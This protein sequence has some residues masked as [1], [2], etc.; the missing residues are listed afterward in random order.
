MKG[1]IV[2]EEIALLAGDDIEAARR[3]EL[4]LHMSNCQACTSLLESY[5]EDRQAMA[6]LRGDGLRAADYASVGESVLAAIKEGIGTARRIPAIWVPL[7]WVAL[8]AAVLIAATIGIWWMKNSK[9]VPVAAVP[10]PKDQVRVAAAK[11]PGAPVRQEAGRSPTALKSSK[12]PDAQVERAQVRP[13]KTESETSPHATGIVP[14]LPAPAERAPVLDDVVIKMET[15]DPN[16]I[17]IWLSS[18][19]GEGR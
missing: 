15:A 4:E 1:H 11:L 17:I 13:R 18:P 3:A 9:P 16:V 10:A 14:I 12:A 2:E 7:R 19:R 5:R 8:A 6:T